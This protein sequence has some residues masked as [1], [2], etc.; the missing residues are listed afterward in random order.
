[1]VI[2]MYALCLICKIKLSYEN[3]ELMENNYS[4]T[5]YLSN[6]K[7]KTLLKLPLIEGM[8]GYLEKL[9][10]F[11]E[12]LMRIDYVHEI[13]DSVGLS[14]L[15][16]EYCLVSTLTFLLAAFKRAAC[17][18]HEDIDLNKL[19]QRVSQVEKEYS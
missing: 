14:I 8:I 12:Q 2:R 7:D 11:H 13:Q 6:P 10:D 3:T 4:I 15:D 18:A 17:H 9:A 16:E 19:R 1:M 5:P